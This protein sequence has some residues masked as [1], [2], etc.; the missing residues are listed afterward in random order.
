SV[1][2]I[3]EN[4]YFLYDSKTAFGR[5]ASILS[6]AKS[7]GYSGPIEVAVNYDNDGRIIE[8]KVLSQTET[9][10]FFRRVERAGFTNQYQGKSIQETFVLDENIAAVTS[11]T[12]SCNG[13]NTA[14]QKANNRT[15][16][17]HFKQKFTEGRAGIKIQPKDILII[18]LYLFA[19]MLSFTKSK[20]QRRFL[21]FF[22]ILSVVLLGFLFKSLLSITHFN[23]LILGNFPDNQYYWYLAVGLFAFSILVLGKNLYFAYICPM[24]IIQDYL[25]KVPVK[26]V[27]IRQKKYYQYPAV[28]LTIGIL[29]YAAIANQPGFLGHEI[30][31]AFFQTNITSWLFGLAVVC[32]VLSL[33]IRR[34]WCRFLC[35]VGVIAKFLQIVRSIVIKR[36]PAKK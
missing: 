7:E 4:F 25:G 12:I 2:K 11:A 19:I 1:Q 24:G 9:P 22:R 14:V 34:F 27:K 16:E 20:I 13:I 3:S 33:F 23:N 31:G 30:F 29:V 17:L 18:F 5:P 35:P 36:K 28:L 21:P 10:G 26:K 32:L 15:C 8:V 6:I